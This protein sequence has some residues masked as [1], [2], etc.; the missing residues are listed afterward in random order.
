MVVIGKKNIKE[1]VWVVK[2]DSMDKTCVVVVKKVKVHPLYKKRFYVNKKY[3]V[4]DEDNKAKKWYVVK[5]REHKP[6]SRLK[7]WILVDIVEEK[8]W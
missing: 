6:I 4:H 7:R 3:Y 8:V 5:I 2:S 1:F